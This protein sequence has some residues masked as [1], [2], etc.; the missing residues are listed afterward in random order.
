MIIEKILM[1]TSQILQ[2]N[3]IINE[4]KEIKSDYCQDLMALFLDLNSF[5]NRNNDN[6]IKKWSQAEYQFYYEFL[7]YEKNSPYHYSNLDNYNLYMISDIM[8]MLGLNLLPLLELYTD[9]ALEINIERQIIRYKLISYF[10]KILS[11]EQI[12]FGVSLID[13]ILFG[14]QSYCDKVKQNELYKTMETYLSHLEKN[15]KFLCER[16]FQILVTALMSAGKSTFINALTGKNVC[17]TENQACTSKIH[18]IIGKAYDDGFIYKYDYDLKLNNSKDELL[19]N[20]TS[21]FTDKINIA[22]YFDGELADKRIIINDSP[23][24]NSS[25][26]QDHKLVTEK[27]IE[28]K[29]FDLIIY[30][31]N[32]SNQLSDDEILHLKFVKENI[33]HNNIIFV[34]N[35]IDEFD[36]DSTSENYITNVNTIKSALEKEGFENSKICPVSAKAGT[37]YRQNQSGELENKKLYSLIDTLVK[38]K[39]ADYYKKEFP[40][41]TVDDRETEEEQLWKTSGLAYVEKII[42]NFVEVRR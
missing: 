17:K 25:T 4:K 1:S 20:A 39:L 24:V 12:D 11:K 16:P 6:I 23:G 14:K 34:V 33:G 10:S 29:E 42:K 31:L 21:N 36:P 9:Y 18:S 3:P 28:E 8:I 37:L 2:F 27:M 5:I 26:N 40:T 22:T 32:Y 7:D 15:Q 35:K 38:T 41:I 13:S 19:H 30:I